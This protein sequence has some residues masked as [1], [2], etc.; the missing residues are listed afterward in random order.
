MPINIVNNIVGITS[1]SLALFVSEYLRTNRSKL[2]FEELDT[3]EEPEQSIL[4]CSTIRSDGS[5]DQQAAICSRTIRKWLNRLGYKWKEVQK[6]VF[7]YGHERENVMEYIETFLSEMKS[8]LPYFVEFSDDGSILPKVYP[9]NCAVDGSDQRLTIMITNDEST[10]SANDG[11]RKV[12]TLDWHGISRLKKK[13]KRIMVLDFFLP[14]SR[15]ILLLLSHQQ[16]EELVNSGIPHE[17]ATYFEYRKIE[18][19]YWTGEHL[20]DQIINKTLCIGESLYPGY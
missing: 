5:I 9:D 15:L 20:L 1:Y 12:W 10:F 18:E 17:A 11:P 3:S 6:S 8:L 16:Q 4:F 14:W 2:A 13:G 7:F 19:G